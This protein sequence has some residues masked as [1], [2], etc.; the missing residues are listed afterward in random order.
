LS[1][2]WARMIV[3]SDVVLKPADVEKIKNLRIFT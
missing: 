1:H 3:K 2:F